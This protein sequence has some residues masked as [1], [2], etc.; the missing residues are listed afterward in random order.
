MNEHRPDNGDPILGQVA[1][2]IATSRVEAAATA[3]GG[4]L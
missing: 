3:S 1:D 2:Q 4:P